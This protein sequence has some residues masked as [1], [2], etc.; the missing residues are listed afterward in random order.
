M[1][2]KSI[3][4]IAHSKN[5]VYLLWFGLLIAGCRTNYV[6]VGRQPEQP[7]PQTLPGR[8]DNLALGN[9]S[10]A[11]VSTPDNY[12]L[13]K[14]QYVL[15]YNRQRGI[16]NWVSWHLSDAWKGDSR[17]STTFRSDTSLPSGWF[18]AK[19]TDYNNTGFDR[20][21]LCP[22]DD[23]DASPADNNA[24]F[25]LTNIVPQSPRHN[26]EVW[27]SLEDYARQLV[28]AGNEL[29]IMAGASGMGGEGTNGPANS[30]ANGQITVPGTLWK[31]IVVL[32]VGDD[33]LNRISTNTRIIAVTIP[34]QQAAADKPWRYY[35]VSVHDVEKLTGYNFLS[36]L[37][38]DL[39]RVLEN[40]IDA[41]L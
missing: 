26:R 9:P 29:Y 28:A 12:L 31:I 41:N 38:T 16:A 33:D 13:V 37:P 21:H 17:R 40:R 23:R 34:N 22:S 20:G 14:P 2:T 19:T 10:G 39:Q 6:P 18:A 32:P 36:T 27:K 1:L 35:V 8:D 7:T 5:L 25:L 3:K 4:V 30:L 15:S 24:T 11:S